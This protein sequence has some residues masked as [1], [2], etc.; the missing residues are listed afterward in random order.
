M[1]RSPVIVTSR[2][3]RR[4]HFAFFLLGA[5][6]VLLG[7]PVSNVHAQ[8]VS[9][10]T[11]LTI[12]DRFEVRIGVLA[13]R[14]NERA[15][16]RWTPTADYLS[17]AVP[18]YRFTIIPYTLPN[19]GIAVESGAID[20]VLTNS[21]NY[22]MLESEYGISRIATMRVPDVV[23]AGHVFGAVI[24]TQAGNPHIE[25]LTDLDGKSFIAVNRNGFGG[26]QMAWRELKAA[27]IDP[28]KD[29]ASLQFMGFPQDE[30][31]YSV[32][33]GRA[34]AG[35]VRTGTLENMA[36]EG[37]INMGDFRV[38]NRRT[39]PGFPY[40]LSTAL[41]P[42]WPF[43]RTPNTPEDLTQKIAIALMSMPRDHPAAKTGRYGGWTVPADYSPVYDLFHELRIGPYAE[44]GKIRLKDVLAR[45]GQW[46]LFAFVI[47]VILA[48]W[49]THTESVVAERTQDLVDA[50]KELE[51][52]NAERR[53]AE[54]EARRR[55]NEIAHVWRFSTMGEMATNLAHELN[56]PLSAI[57]NYARGCARR[58]KKG[59]TDPKPLL[60]AMDAISTQAERAGEIIR[61]VRAFLRKD[62]PNRQRLD[63]RD[64]VHEVIDLLYSE[65]QAH[66]ARVDISFSGMPPL[67]EADP[68]QLQQVILNLMRNGMEAM[69]TLPLD[70]RVLR[71]AVS[72]PA[73]GGTQITVSDCGTGIP[74]SDL[75][76]I[77]DPF[78]T[79]KA[80]GLGMGLSIS[81]SII[82]SHGGRLTATSNIGG[83]TAFSVFLPASEEDASHAA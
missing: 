59:D 10:S 72:P 41:Y 16:Q 57:G 27:G 71:I 42:E 31:V 34:D 48:A 5:L 25:S 29:I 43:A 17:Q 69:N 40:E 75:N 28:F 55:D 32:R 58:L 51:R 7:V 1:N 78:Y 14:G 82:E 60:E 21:G 49:A 35:T 54:E 68:V 76:Q 33:D 50:N 79:T 18:E 9:P 37:K 38:L 62:E 77:F 67:V 63:V 2:P 66:G 4:C 3:P 24:I 64:T 22:V 19:I 47:I 15:I 73:N 80:N 26:F 74:E 13:F 12:P 23:E 46:F 61:R 39:Q 6:L 65:I 8:T 53:K 36:A 52:Q 56:Q 83:G 70:E 30:V 11:D 44:L 20:F 81:R 45:F